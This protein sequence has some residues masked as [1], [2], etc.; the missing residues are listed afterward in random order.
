MMLYTSKIGGTAIMRH[1]ETGV[2]AAPQDQ[3]LVDKLKLDSPDV[4]KW[5]IMEI[6]EAQP[7]RLAMFDA[8]LMHAALPFG[9]SG[10]GVK[11]RTVYTR[12]VR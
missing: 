7:N 9:G 6:A 5:Q 2:M 10:E 8:S 11:S 12:F 4:D 3:D 1:K